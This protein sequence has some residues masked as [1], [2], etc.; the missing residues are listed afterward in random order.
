MFELCKNGGLDDFLKK[1]TKY[2]PLISWRDSEAVQRA[3]KEIT[4][5]STKK[6]TVLSMLVDKGVGLKTSWALEVAKG[7]AFLHGKNPPIIHRDLKCANVLVGDDLKGKINDFG[8]S[9]HVG[10]EEEKTMTQVGTPHFMAPEVFS[11][12][13]E[14]KYYGKEVDVYSYGMLLIEIFYDGRIMKAFKKG[15]GQMVIMSRIMKGWRPDLKLVREEDEE[16]ADIM[17]KCWKANPE[18]RPTFKE[19]IK[20]FQ[21]KHFMLGSPNSGVRDIGDL[22]INQEDDK[23][24]TVESVNKNK[25]AVPP[26]VERAGTDMDFSG[27]I[28]PMDI[29]AMAKEQ[30]EKEA[31]KIVDE[32]V[33]TVKIDQETVLFAMAACSGEG[34]GLKKEQKQ[35]AEAVQKKEERR[36]MKA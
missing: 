2:G 8:E 3:H 12:E 32:K 4:K 18:E 30:K 15:W 27:P 31:A 22:N 1:Y 36:R 11:T 26:K 6:G 17:G 19:L 34:G 25:L 28:D 5:V 35:K 10:G 29:F 33:K 14:D 21:K 9:R 16:L 7:C 24:E 13:L 20:F 23:P